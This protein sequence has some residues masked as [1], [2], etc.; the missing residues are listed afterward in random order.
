MFNIYIYIKHTP[1]WKITSCPNACY[2]CNFFLNS[3]T[4]LRPSV[5]KIPSPLHPIAEYGS[6]RRNLGCTSTFCKCKCTW[7]VPRCTSGG[8]DFCP[9]NIVILFFFKTFIGSAR[10]LKFCQKP[11]GAH[12]KISIRNSRARMAYST[13]RPLQNRF[14]IFLTPVY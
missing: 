2:F 3:W 14:S 11:L 6:F 8:M 1:G 9:G 4:L 7:E 5:W 13:I 10:L 12:Q